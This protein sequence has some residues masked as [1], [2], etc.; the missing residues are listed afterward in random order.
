MAKQWI[1]LYTEV[2][3]DRKLW[4]LKPIEQ[5]AFF[6]LCALAGIEDDGGRLPDFED[7]ELE[8]Q[9]PLKLK[10]G[11]LEAIMSRLIDLGLVDT[12][13]LGIYKVSQYEKR[14]MSNM[15]EAER[16][17]IYRDKKKTNEG[18]KAD[19]CPDTCP[20]NVPEMSPIEKELRIKNKEE[21][22]EELREV[23]ESVLKNARDEK[24]APKHKHGTYKHVLL[25]DAEVGKLAKRFPDWEKKIQNLDDY[26]QNN[27]KKH[28]DDHYLTIC[29]WADDD[30]EKAKAK[31]SPASVNEYPDI[32]TMI[33]AEAMQ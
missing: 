20:D 26:L 8:L 14:Q 11:E 18:Q 24:P 5:L 10:K 15:T 4:K 3:H 21:D 22:K 19:K 27:R 23:K 12:Y 6:Y 7:I 30:A 16:K 17:A 31:K 2:V 1:K 13:P 28:Y 9:M 32:Y 25:T 29:K 33:Q